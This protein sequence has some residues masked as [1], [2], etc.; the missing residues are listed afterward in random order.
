MRFSLL[1]LLIAC[2]HPAQDINSTPKDMNELFT[3]SDQ[4][5]AYLLKREGKRS[6]NKIIL[7]TK[8]LSRTTGKE[9]E[10]SVVVSRLGSLRD[11][12]NKSS[13]ALLPEISQF[14]VWFEKK[15]YFS[16]IKL[17][18]NKRSLEVISKSPEKKWNFKKSYKLPKGRYICFFS[19]LP[20][21]MKLQNLLFHAARKKVELFVIWDNFP[22]HRELYDGLS[23]EPF[24]RAELELSRHDKNE[25][26]Y[27]LDI[28]NQVIFYH[29]DKKLRFQK[30]IWVSQGI[31]VINTSKSEG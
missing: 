10:S 23:Q 2:A 18:R 21:C 19:Q 29:F 28:G 26:R 1:L 17:N 14:K 13:Q 25:V 31:S 6:K 4:S 9:L 12:K 24:V 30:M 11:K 5:G 20:E 8:M 7:R 15:E 3:Y 16:Q 27:S 22:Y